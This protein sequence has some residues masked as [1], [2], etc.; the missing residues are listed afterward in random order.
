MSTVLSA[1]QAWPE[2]ADHPPEVCGAGLGRA[3]HGV[4]LG[5]QRPAEHALEPAHEWGQSLVG[6]D[7]DGVAAVPVGPVVGLPQ[8]RREPDRA[9]HGQPPRLDRASN[10]LLEGTRTLLGDLG[11]HP[12]GVDR[13]EVAVDNGV[14]LAHRECDRGVVAVAADRLTARNRGHGSGVAV[15]VAGPVARHRRSLG[16]RGSGRGFGGAG[17]GGWGGRARWLR[18][19]VAARARSQDEGGRQDRRGRRT[20]TRGHWLV[21]AQ[22]TDRRLPAFHSASWNQ[23]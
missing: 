23:V 1:R 7:G 4:A 19:G 10:E 18:S 20:T 9:Q 8:A 21:F 22:H 12:V 16:G 17:G 5:G 3:A 15:V 6:G 14:E 13:D 2:R 11:L